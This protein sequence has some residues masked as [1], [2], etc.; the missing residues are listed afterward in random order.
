MFELGV[1]MHSAFN[2][3]KQLKKLEPKR[4]QADDLDLDA[5]PAMLRIP[6][7]KKQEAD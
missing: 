6:K 2:D 3:P 4:L 5:I 7:K 1:I